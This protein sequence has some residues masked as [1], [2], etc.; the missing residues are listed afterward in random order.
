MKPVKFLIIT[1]LYLASNPSGS[2]ESAFKLSAGSKTIEFETANTDWSDFCI[3]KKWG[4]ARFKMFKEQDKFDYGFV[5]IMSDK[6]SQKDFSDYCKN[7]YTEVK[8]NDNTVYEYS[9]KENQNI[10]SCLW[11]SEKFSTFFFWKDGLII[12]ATTSERSVLQTITLII[13]KAKAYER[14]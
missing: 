13:D 12:M 2:A 9:E 8:K 3:N 6:I 5:K 1:V 11:A 4:C 10:S 7:T 14:I